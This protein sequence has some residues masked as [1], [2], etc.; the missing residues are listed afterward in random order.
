MS[1]LKSIPKVPWLNSI[2]NLLR[3]VENPIPV[4]TE[5]IEKYG[6]TYAFYLGGIRYGIISIDPEFNQHVLQKNNRNYGKTNLQLDILGKYVGKGLLTS[7]GDYWLKQRRLIQP[8]FHRS[9]LA[10]LT[11]IMQGVC[12]DFVQELNIEID[13]GKEDFEID[14][15]MMELAFRMVAKSLFST[16]YNDEMLNALSGNITILQK[17]IIREVRQPYLNWWFKLSGKIN[18][19]LDIAKDSDNLLLEIINERKRSGEQKDDLLDMLLSSRYEDTGEGM[20]DQQ[21]LAESLILFV[22]GHETTANALAWLMYLL[23]KNPEVL[24]KLRNEI[25][26]KLGDSK[27]GF[28]KLREMTYASQV[29]KESMRLYP[30][31]WIMDRVALNDDEIMGYKIPKGAMINC[32]IYGAHH[33]EKYWP[34]AEKFDPDRF[35]PENVKARPNFTYFPFGGGPRLCIGQNFAMMEMQLILIELTRNFDFELVE[36]KEIVPQPLITLRP[37][38]GI[39]MKLKKRQP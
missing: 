4:V 29:I 26:Q 10:L 17:F 30:P 25:D 33:S 36:D 19:H 20:G 32:F 1:K 34:D 13:S 21:L 8:G 15:K 37:K 14:E 23:W 31:A 22:A 35:E 11:E 2:A 7:D 12:D 39:R 27:A 24:Q 6:D 28:E 3:F 5:T 38:N 16:N 9:K 18:K